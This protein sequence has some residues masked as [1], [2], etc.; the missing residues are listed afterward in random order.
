MKVMATSPPLES[1]STH[2]EQKKEKK[3]IINKD[4]GLHTKQYK[5][6]WSPK[7]GW[8]K[9]KVKWGGRFSRTVVA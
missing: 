6:D 3:K 4:T 1:L 8:R 2:I 7:V 5:S 9:T